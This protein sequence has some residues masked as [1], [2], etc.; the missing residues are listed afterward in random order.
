MIWMYHNWF[1]YSPIEQDLSSF[2]FLTIMDKVAINI[3]GQV[4]CE[5]KFSNLGRYLGSTMYLLW[6]YFKN[7]TKRN[8]MFSYDI[9]SNILLGHKEDIYR[10]K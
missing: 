1:T 4:L 8:K 2:E 3:H 10:G 7:M 9:W 6:V 5:Y